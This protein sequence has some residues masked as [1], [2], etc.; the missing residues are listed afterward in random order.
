MVDQLA[1]QFD[2]L[3]IVSFH[4]HSLDLFFLGLK[5]SYLKV[6]QLMVSVSGIFLIYCLPGQNNYALQMIKTT[7]YIGESPLTSGIQLEAKLEG[8]IQ[9]SVPTTKPKALRT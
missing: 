5:V 7:H 2:I 9:K 1:S 3:A 8:N 4:C 6:S